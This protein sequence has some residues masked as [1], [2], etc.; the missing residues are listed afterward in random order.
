MGGFSFHLVRLEANMTLD[1][2]R[3]SF[4]AAEISP[5]T[6]ATGLTTRSKCKGFIQDICSDA[7]RISR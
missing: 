6:S 1:N 5:H 2:M 7:T 3:L 4:R